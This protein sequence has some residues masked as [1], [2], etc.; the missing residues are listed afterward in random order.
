SHADP[1]SAL[2]WSPDGQLVATAAGGGG[3][4]AVTL[5]DAADGTRLA[6]LDPQSPVLSLSF[7]PDGQQLAVLGSSGALQIWSLRR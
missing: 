5:W 3:A 6:E 1:V 7:S 4:P 2:A